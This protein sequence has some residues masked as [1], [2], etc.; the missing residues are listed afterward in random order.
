MQ[1]L[2]IWA[3]AESICLMR[4]QAT[5]QMLSLHS[6]APEISE[7]CK[8]L[9]DYPSAALHHQITE[10]REVLPEVSVQKYFRMASESKLLAK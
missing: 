9:R 5:S 8:W 10:L 6:Q 3:E 7:H 2:L 1:R 4:Q